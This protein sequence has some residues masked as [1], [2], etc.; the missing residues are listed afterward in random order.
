M[1]LLINLLF[2]SL[3]FKWMI[4]VG[5]SAVSLHHVL[6]SVLFQQIHLFLHFPLDKRQFFTVKLTASKGRNQQRQ[7]LKTKFSTLM[8]HQQNICDFAQKRNL[9]LSQCA[10]CRSI[11]VDQLHQDRYL[12]GKIDHTVRTFRHCDIRL[13]PQV[14]RNVQLSWLS[15]SNVWLWILCLVPWDG[16]HSS[17][18]PGTCVKTLHGQR[19]LSSH[20]D[21]A[22]S[23]NGNLPCC[24]CRT[25]RSSVCGKSNLALLTESLTNRPAALFQWKICRDQIH[26]GGH[27]QVFG[28]SQPASCLLSSDF[29]NSWCMPAVA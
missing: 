16:M 10:W 28:G 22:P 24:E 21:T 4:A 6:H 25:V 19:S 13:S 27:N 20:F 2:L 8:F 18:R 5:L 14:R 12:V 26:G 9:W 15:P 3:S 7:C 29:L 23:A 1:L 17:S 11:F